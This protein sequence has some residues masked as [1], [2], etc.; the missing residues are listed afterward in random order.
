MGAQLVH[1]QA[2]LQQLGEKAQ[3]RFEEVG[4]AVVAAHSRR[5]LVRAVADL[6]CLVQPQVERGALEEADVNVG[7]RLGEGGAR[8]FGL[9]DRIRSRLGCGLGSPC[10]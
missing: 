9:L 5:L 4:E 8:C 3:R 7:R 1:A 10:C 2:H 6:A